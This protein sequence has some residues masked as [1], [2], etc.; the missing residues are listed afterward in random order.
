M[1]EAFVVIDMQ[2][3]FKQPSYKRIIPHIRMKIGGA[4]YFDHHVIFVEYK[5][6]GDTL[7]ELVKDTKAH[8]PSKVHFITKKGCNG[9]IELSKKLRKLKIERINVGGV[10]SDVCVMETIE[11]V[12][13]L[14]P[15]LKVSVLES[16]CGQNT[17]GSGGEYGFGGLGWTRKHSNVKLVKRARRIA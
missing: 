9:A 13:L 12:A 5:D 8:H 2:P 1:S 7:P 15:E 16:C 10:N 11:G 3:E 17:Y 6:C 4:K 14:M